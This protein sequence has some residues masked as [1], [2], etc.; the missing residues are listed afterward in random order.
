MLIEHKTALACCAQQVQAGV[1]QL[2]RVYRMKVSRINEINLHDAM[3]FCKNTQK[4][5]LKQTI[6]AKSENY[7][8]FCE[9]FALLI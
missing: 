4:N 1:A 2:L 3:I 5:A 6:C 9:T 7:N 8:V